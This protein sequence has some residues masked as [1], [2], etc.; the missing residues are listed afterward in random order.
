MKPP[1]PVSRSAPPTKSRVQRILDGEEGP[2]FNILHSKL[3]QIV[4]NHVLDGV[5]FLKFSGDL[6]YHSELQR[7]A[8]IEYL[9]DGNPLSLQTR[10]EILA[11]QDFPLL[12]AHISMYQHFLSLL[13]YFPFRHWENT[14]VTLDIT[15]H[16][17]TLAN[18]LWRACAL[19]MDCHNL[20]YTR[21]SKGLHLCDDATIP[22]WQ[23]AVRTFLSQSCHRYLRLY[24]VGLALQDM[25]TGN[26]V[27]HDN[28]P[29]SFDP[30]PCSVPDHEI[31][32][33]KTLQNSMGE[34]RDRLHEYI[35]MSRHKSHITTF[36]QSVRLVAPRYYI[37]DTLPQ[38]TTTMTDVASQFA[39]SV[40]SIM[41][42]ANTPLLQPNLDQ[43]AQLYG[44][45]H[46]VLHTTPPSANL[47]FSPPLATTTAMVAPTMVPN[48][49]T[50]IEMYTDSPN[51]CQLHFQSSGLTSLSDHDNMEDGD[52]CGTS[53]DLTKS[54]GISPVATTEV[55][56]IYTVC[57]AP[58]PPTVCAAYEM[59]STTPT[60]VDPKV[61]QRFSPTSTHIDVSTVLSDTCQMNFQSSG[62]DNLY[63]GDQD[64]HPSGVTHVDPSPPEPDTDVIHTPAIL[65]PPQEET[66][67]V[68]VVQEM[69]VDTHATSS[70]GVPLTSTTEKGEDDL[71]MVP[72]AKE[73]SVAAQE[74]IGTSEVLSTPDKERDA[75][76]SPMFDRCTHVPLTDH[77]SGFAQEVPDTAHASDPPH[78]TLSN[79]TDTPHNIGPYMPNTTSSGHVPLPYATLASDSMSLATIKSVPSLL[80]PATGRLT[81]TSPAGIQ[82]PSIN[83]LNQHSM[84]P[85]CSIVPTSDSTILPTEPL[86]DLGT[87]PGVTMVTAIHPE[88]LQD[89]RHNYDH[90]YSDDIGD[91]HMTDHDMHDDSAPDDEPM[92]A[93]TSRGNDL[94]V[95]MQSPILDGMSITTDNSIQPT[96]NV[97][98]TLDVWPFTS[99]TNEH[100]LVDEINNAMLARIVPDYYQDLQSVLCDV[101]LAA[102]LKISRIYATDP[103][104][105]QLFNTRLLEEFNSTSSSRRDFKYAGLPASPTMFSTNYPVLSTYV[106]PPPPTLTHSYSTITAT[107]SVP[108]NVTERPIAQ[109]TNSTTNFLW[110]EAGVTLRFDKVDFELFAHIL[111]SY[112]DRLRSSNPETVSQ[113][114]TAIINKYNKE[115][116]FRAVLHTGIEEFAFT[117]QAIVTPLHSFQLATVAPATPVTAAERRHLSDITLTRT[118]FTADTTIDKVTITIECRISQD[119]RDFIRDSINEGVQYEEIATTIVRTIPTLTIAV[120]PKD[121]SFRHHTCTMHESSYYAT[122]GQLEGLS[123]NDSSVLDSTKFSPGSL[124]VPANRVWTRTWLG[125][126]CDHLLGHGQEALADAHMAALQWLDKNDIGFAQQQLSEN[127]NF[128]TISI[129]TLDVVIQTIHFFPPTP[130]IA[131]LLGKANFKVVRLVCATGCI[132]HT[133]GNFTYPQLNSILQHNFVRAIPSG[134]THSFSFHGQLLMSS[135]QLDHAA[136]RLTESIRLAISKIPELD[137]T[138][139]QKKITAVQILRDS[140]ADRC[141]M[142][143]TCII[144]GV[145]SLLLGEDGNARVMRFR[146]VKALFDSLNLGPLPEDIH[147]QLISPTVH[148]SSIDICDVDGNIIHSHHFLA[149]RLHS[150]IQTSWNNTVRVG[151]IERE[152]I[153]KNA[154]TENEQ[155][156]IVI[157]PPP[158]KLPYFTYV[159][160]LTSQSMMPLFLQSRIVASA[161][162]LITFQTVDP[163]VRAALTYIKNVTD[164]PSITIGVPM[165]D[166]ITLLADKSRKPTHRRHFPTF[167]VT[168]LAQLD[169]S[170]LTELQKTLQLAPK[171]QMR[172]NND[173]NPRRVKHLND[174]YLVDMATHPTAFQNYPLPPKVSNARPTVKALRFARCQLNWTPLTLLEHIESFDGFPLE[175]LRDIIHTSPGEFIVVLH[176]NTDTDQLP[177]SHLSHLQ[178]TRLQCLP[179]H[180]NTI[181]PHSAKSLGPICYPTMAFEKEG[182]KKQPTKRDRKSL[183]PETTVAIPI[184]GP[185]RV[186][187]TSPATQG[188]DK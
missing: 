129:F 47:T 177:T 115:T 65:R 98:T 19:L 93:S 105:K 67:Q 20:D 138:A 64:A 183:A 120:T 176:W 92:P 63:D 148:P 91:H 97:I 139:T 143:D 51:T 78:M 90:Y 142:V 21:Y 95:D 131:Y 147:S 161:R 116:A 36:L 182:F 165:Y 16:P 166:T 140:L 5:H 162:N 104:F 172:L 35:T 167:G 30:T 28:A 40:P 45:L 122:H 155:S 66:N 119:A 49:S 146:T 173:A 168:I 184:R 113:A 157:P 9:N 62:Y 77:A 42:S 3:L 156:E 80:S 54:C 133:S 76:I 15:L 118:L 94:S 88:Q 1:P 149:L 153:T 141:A 103:S 186:T 43:V 160:T 89:P 81:V 34:T 58:N 50:N 112:S 137:T 154:G 86:T 11:S 128:P 110:Q 163:H 61:A 126:I 125:R 132:V 68:P 13:Q 178:Y 22:A 33:L 175:H 96:P 75:V 87:P 37:V 117:D 111:P 99:A 180:I 134:I 72:V 136:T 71:S 39:T 7:F 127:D 84:D 114:R 144:A 124:Y 164:L 150:P 121:Q 32:R 38:D 53:H 4:C 57:A 107:T 2:I 79:S 106:T 158:G 135:S 145:H 8:I 123:H 101:S 59:S 70:P 60:M 44:G 12:P 130:A 74:T 174:C 83:S 171:H 159:A 46:P 109:P 108:V 17:R 169:L 188:T 31:Q 14:T 73:M 170:Q 29:V 151:Q 18:I 56:R 187:L 6:D 181:H 24:A 48:A 69:S 185:P 23:G 26:T 82:Y 25:I 27:F 100:A 52:L 152:A 102:R 179:F 10:A 41:M 85:T 55:P